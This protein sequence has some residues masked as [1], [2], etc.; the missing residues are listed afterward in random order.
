MM[1]N[2]SLQAARAERAAKVQVERRV[3]LKLSETP[4][5]E[6]RGRFKRQEQHVSPLHAISVPVPRNTAAMVEATVTSDKR[7][8]ALTM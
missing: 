6:R 4:D 2:A 3:K 5:F 8:S 7:T 1:S